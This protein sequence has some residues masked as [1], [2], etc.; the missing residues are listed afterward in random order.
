M[1]K[2][3]KLNYTIAFTDNVYTTLLLI[4]NTLFNNCTWLVDTAFRT[5]PSTN[6]FHK[7]IKRTVKVIDRENIGKVPLII[8]Q[9]KSYT[10][11]NCTSHEI[12]QIFPGQT[13]MVRLIM[14]NLLSIQYSS[15]K[16]KAITGKSLN[17]CKI[18]DVN[19]ISQ[20]HSSHGCN[21]YNYTIWSSE[22]KLQIILRIR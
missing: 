8:C 19:E 12:G 11:R 4:L 5:T 15:T 21:E 2:D 13:L 18:I 7:V 16:L 9:Y 20:V 10:E 22:K 1:Q 17:A 14:P 6:V 3:V